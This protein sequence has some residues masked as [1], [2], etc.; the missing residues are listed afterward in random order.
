MRELCR[1]DLYFLCR[2]VLGYEDMED[3]TDL[4]YRLCSEL[5]R[6]DTIATLVKYGVIRS[7]DELDRYLRYLILVFRGAFKTSICLGKVIQ[8]LIRDRD[9]QIGIGSDTKERAA[10]RTK[11]LRDVIEQNE[12]LKWLFP[13]VFYQTP[14]N[15][16]DLWK[17]DE[18]NVR[19]T[20]RDLRTGGFTVSSITAFGLFPMPVGAHFTHVY[21][22]DLENDDNC[23]NDDMIEKLNTALGLF[24]PILRPTAPFLISGT[25]YNETGPNNLLS[26]RWYTYK[27]PIETGVDRK[28]TFPKVYP[29]PVIDRIRRDI[30]DDWVWNGQYLLKA[31][32]R[33]DKFLYPFRGVKLKKVTVEAATIFHEHGTLREAVS[34]AE[35]TVFVTVDPSGGA[36]EQTATRRSDKVGWCV[37]AV[38]VKGRWHILDMGAKHLDD[39]ALIDFLFYLS[40]KWRPYAIG[41][42]KM[43]HLEPYM[44]LAYKVRGRAL[45]TFPLTPKRRD[46]SE[47]I[48]ALNAFWETMYFA[49]TLDLEGRVQGWYTDQEHG[50]DDLDALAY[51]IDVV[52]APTPE[53]LKKQKEKYAE[54]EAQHQL[55]QLPPKERREWERIQKA[56]KRLPEDDA[57]EH[58]WSEFCGGY[59][60][61]AL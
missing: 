22:D 47:R 8:W 29:R 46:K 43:P 18:F 54:L 10:G 17:M 6:V 23:K 31:S 14:A 4:H 26:K 24:I 16:A 28:P 9:A 56:A 32:T 44:R 51:Q 33:T 25:I 2:Y 3:H 39:P 50:D 20:R 57:W 60:R 61:E 34:L 5:D 21:I 1:T 13:D 7:G 15:K 27:R 37:N 48:R 49:D 11:D 58:E 53:Q 38:D 36:S 59:A 40:D 45:V 35:C 19:R 41:I 42:E 52:H 55:E 30:P 12:K